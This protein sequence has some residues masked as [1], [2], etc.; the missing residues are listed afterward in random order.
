M[1]NNNNQTLLMGTALT[2]LFTER[3]T[4]E[5]KS[6]HTIKY[7]KLDL[8]HFFTTLPPDIRI[9]HIKEKHIRHFLIEQKNTRISYTG[10]HI[11]NKSLNRKLY[12]I[13]SFFKF[14]TRENIIKE[15]PTQYMT[16]LQARK[17]LPQIASKSKIKE[18][19]ETIPYKKKLQRVM[20]TFLYQTGMRVSELTSTNIEDINFENNTLRIIGKGDKIRIIHIDP[21]FLKPVKLYLKERMDPDPSHPL[22]ARPG[23]GRHSTWSIANLL[24]QLSLKT[25]TKITPHTL[26][27][28]FATHMLEAGFPISYIQD[29]LGHNSLNTTAIYLHVSNPQLIQQYNRAA[30]SLKI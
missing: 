29:Y 24:K 23:G 17:N 20:I 3:E 22:F 21:E 12:T 15:N 11:T 10:K 5:G 8:R 27:H 2:K 7:H 1:E 16:P 13:R 30:P 28:S 4:L 19:I 9:I 6:P 14:L 25:G 18:L 26:R